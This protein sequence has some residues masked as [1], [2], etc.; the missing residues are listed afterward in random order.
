MLYFSSKNESSAPKINLILNGVRIDEKR[1]TKYLGII[2]DH[3]L[4]YADHINQVKSKLIKG[5][6]ILAKVRHY[7]P[8]N[9]LSNTYNANIQ[10]HIDYGLNIWGRSAKIHL[11][12][13]IRQQKNL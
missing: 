11:E 10:P 5:N 7:I 12:D 6:I 2:L 9:L 13:V 4:T 1:T 8:H 3:K